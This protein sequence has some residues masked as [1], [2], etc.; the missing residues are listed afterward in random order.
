[1]GS[2][3]LLSLFWLETCALATQGSGTVTNL[4]NQCIGAR[5]VRF[6]W[7]HFIFCIFVSYFVCFVIQFQ[8]VYLLMSL[9]L[10][11]LVAH[12]KSTRT[13]LSCLFQCAHN[14]IWFIISHIFR[15][16]KMKQCQ[17]LPMLNLNWVYIWLPLW[18]PPLLLF[19][20]LFL[21]ARWAPPSSFRL[22]FDGR[23]RLYNHS[24]A[25]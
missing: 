17:P 22:S 6:L 7:Q 12:S 3:V 16:C 10:L 14:F 20:P 25:L 2:V 8:S 24:N 19:S 15:L 13:A 21:W 23:H 18:T 9:W 11:I 5:T 1:M 4:F